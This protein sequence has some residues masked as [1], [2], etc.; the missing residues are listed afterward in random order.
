MVKCEHECAVMKI[1]SNIV[2]LL[3]NW[4]YTPFWKDAGNINIAKSVDTGK[5]K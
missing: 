1:N 5:G 4:D 3:F 2:E